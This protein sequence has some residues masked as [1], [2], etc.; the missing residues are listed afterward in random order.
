VLD[1]EPVNSDE[2]ITAMADL[3][4][5]T[6]G[7]QIEVAVV[8]K[9]D[10]W[11]ALCDAD[12]MENAL[13]QLDQMPAEV[14]LQNTREDKD[15]RPNLAF[16]EPLARGQIGQKGHD[17]LDLGQ[18]RNMQDPQHRVEDEPELCICGVRLS[19][20]IVEQ[21]QAGPEEF[22]DSTASAASTEAPKTSGWPRGKTSCPSCGRRS[23][24]P[25]AWVCCSAIRRLR[26]WPASTSA[27]YR[28]A[29]SAGGSRR[30][31]SCTS[32]SPPSRLSGPGRRGRR[33]PQ[34]RRPLVEQG[35]ERDAGEIDFLRPCQSQQM[36]QRPGK[37]VE[38]Q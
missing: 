9:T 10:L 19:R 2:L 34:R 8:P 4:R 20:V 1:P 30:A 3:I 25:K 23:S 29:G 22:D 16:T 15:R 18:R 37:P 26:N 17:G 11:T 36:V 38:L 31:R 7:P 27:S 33:L 6:V 12:Q 21:R 28:V 5:R 35:D 32:P 24:H 14:R 13:I